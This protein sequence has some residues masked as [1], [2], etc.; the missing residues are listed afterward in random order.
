VYTWPR[1]ITAGALF[2][3]L[4]LRRW[5]Q[6]EP[7]CC[8]L[9]KQ[10]ANLC[11]AILA[12]AEHFFCNA[13]HTPPTQGRISAC[14]GNRN[15]DSNRLLLADMLLTC[16]R[17]DVARTAHR[18]SC[19]QLQCLLFVLQTTTEVKPCTSKAAVHCKFSQR[20]LTLH[21]LP[22]NSFSVLTL[23]CCVCT[24]STTSTRAIPIR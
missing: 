23:L 13:D 9:Q 17:D 15:T 3:A 2:A 20:R 8:V 6:Q 7:F 22:L 24:R 16:I 19:A 12:P 14:R 10:A 4:L 21:Y 11:V 18:C 1:C 5:Q